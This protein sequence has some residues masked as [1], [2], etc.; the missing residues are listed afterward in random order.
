MYQIDR[1]ANNITKLTKRKFGDLGFR[2]RE[3]LQEWIVKNPQVLNVKSEEKAELLIIQKEFDGFHETNERLDLLALDKSGNLVVIENK[4]DDSGRDV[5]WQAL[6][7][8][9]YCSTLTKNQI[10]QIFQDYLDRHFTSRT[11]KDEILEHLG[12]REDE[13]LPKLNDGDQRIIFV[14]NDYRQ[15]VTS[16]VMWLLDHG[17]QIQCFKATPYSL[18]EE[19]F[20]QVD[21]IIPPPEATDFMIQ[22]TKKT[23]EDH[24]ESEKVAETKADLLNFWKLV[25]TSFEERNLSFLDN[26]SPKPLFHLGFSK[27][28]GYFAMAIAKAGFRVELYFGN[29]AEKRCFDAMEKRKDRLI[30]SFGEGLVWERLDNKKASRIKYEMP[31]EVRSQLGDW[32][33]QDAKKDYADW[34]ATELER[35]YQALYPVWEEV[36]KELSMK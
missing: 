3:N 9:S 22:M 28:Q 34:F 11:A 35:L 36:H 4:L 30:T 25:K 16:T 17:L 14:A 20:L 29:D 31:S 19:L 2:E 7:Y 8:A 5:V 12:Y 27:W 26:V 10:I 32:S 33:D 18:N 13:E 23:R 24:V 21:Q 1:D 15:E 6:K